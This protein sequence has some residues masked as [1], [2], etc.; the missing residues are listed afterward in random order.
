MIITKQLKLY[1]TNEQKEELLQLM[2]QYNIVANHI[3]KLAHQNKTY[4]KN[5]IQKQY[6][7]DIRKQ[8]NLSSQM[9]IRAIDKVANSYKKDKKKER[10]F[11]STGAVYYDQRNSNLKEDHVSL[12][13][14]D[15]RLIIKHDGGDHQE[16]K[17]I[18]INNDFKKQLKLVYRRNSG[19]FYL[20]FG[21][22]K[23]E[24]PVIIVKDYIGVDL[25]V[26]NIAVTSDGEI[27]D[28]VKIEKNRVKYQKI[29]S[30][31]QKCGSRSA[32]RHL[33]RLSGRERAFKR[34]VNH[35]ISKSLVGLAIGTGRGIAL[36]DLS[37]IR[38]RATVRKSQRDRHGK[39]AFGELRNFIQY[40]AGLSGVPVILVDAHYTS[41]TC[42]SCGYIKGN[43]RNGEVFK[44]K[45]CG[46]E[47]HADF[48]AAL[49]I[50][51]R[52]TVNKPIVAAAL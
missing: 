15:T 20:Q 30:D 11:R 8:F 14:L 19:E 51:S 31:L 5:T 13:G 41:Q 10:H 22:E 33:K 9:T 38:E 43:N 17:E 27:F 6:Y 25:G 26:N 52:A 42:S 46:F 12:R 28:S 3:S 49:N 50:S 24:K 40:K 7:Q 23:I 36:E 34:D 39:W 16:I 44:C 47:S 2:K 37:G 4:N 21:V 45:S 32:K 1:P 48:N 29:K 18:I 35:C